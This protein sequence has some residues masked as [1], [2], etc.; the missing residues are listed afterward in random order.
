MLRQSEEDERWQR[1][2]DAI[3]DAMRITGFEGVC[4]ASIAA[5]KATMLGL[6]VTIDLARA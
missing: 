5:K 2:Q 6:P 1:G 3:R 4:S